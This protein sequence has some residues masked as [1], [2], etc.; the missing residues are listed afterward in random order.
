MKAR[1][2]SAR[3]PA[4]IKKSLD[5]EADVDDSGGA[6]ANVIVDKG[7]DDDD[8]EDED[9]GMI[10]V[11]EDGAG[12]SKQNTQQIRRPEDSGSDDEVHGV[13]VKKILEMKKGIEEMEGLGADNAGTKSRGA[14][15][16]DNAATKGVDDALRGEREKEKENIKKD[17]AKVRVAIQQL[18]SAANPLGK[19][20]DYVQEDVEAMQKEL[21]TW[22]TENKTHLKSIV[23]EKNITDAELEPLK[24]ELATL[25]S[26]IVDQ[27][28]LIRSAKKN[29]LR[30]EEKIKRMITN[31]IIQGGKD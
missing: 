27:I 21:I 30:N 5:L 26:N 8:D 3:P 24:K 1:P 14:S 7:D 25:E 13:L 29:I 15:G 9:G 16:A 17:V 11:V 23:Q 31:T 19:M 12:D 10:N 2:A 6:V 4:K 22:K 20:M 28:D 18:S